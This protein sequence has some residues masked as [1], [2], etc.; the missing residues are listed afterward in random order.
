MTGKTGRSKRIFTFYTKGLSPKHDWLRRRMS[1]NHQAHVEKKRKCSS[2]DR[3]PAS[4]WVTCMHVDNHTAIRVC[5][6]QHCPV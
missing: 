2:L 6:F 1:E 5:S 4:D 3:R